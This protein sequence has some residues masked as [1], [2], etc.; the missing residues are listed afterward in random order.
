MDK[1]RELEARL[2]EILKNDTPLEEI[3][4]LELGNTWR[5]L[6]GIKNEANE[7]MLDILVGA[8]RDEKGRSM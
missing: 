4:A 2:E 7:I 3:G 8:T 6:D 5:I 1:V